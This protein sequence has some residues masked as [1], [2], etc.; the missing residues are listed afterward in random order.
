MK[1][2]HFNFKVTLLGN[3]FACVGWALAHISS[4]E[5][6]RRLLLQNEHVEKHDLASRTALLL[7]A[8]G[9]KGQWVRPSSPPLPS[10][11]SKSAPTLYPLHKP[12]STTINLFGTRAL[13]STAI[14]ALISI[15]ND[16]S[17]CR[18][19]EQNP[20]SAQHET[21]E[22]LRKSALNLW[23]VATSAGSQVARPRQPLGKG[24]FTQESTLPANRRALAISWHRKCST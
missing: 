22:P 3:A 6:S 7:L 5:N 10:Q 24:A 21:C 11:W 23:R 18:T 8:Q 17:G 14:Q 15:N 4:S 9:H 13:I 16:I 20:N 1:D 2:K 12:L 19:M